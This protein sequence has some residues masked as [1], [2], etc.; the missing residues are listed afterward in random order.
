MDAPATSSGIAPKRSARG[1]SWLRSALVYGLALAA[2]VGSAI[3]FLKTMPAFGQGQG[4]WRASMLAGSQDADLYTR[5]QVAIGGLLALNRSETMYY[6]A[7]TDSQGDVLRSRCTYRIHGTPP[8]A[9]WWSIT[10]YAEDLLSA[11]QTLDRWPEKVRIMQDNW[12]GKSQG[13]R[14]FFK[15]N[16][17]DEEIEVFTTRP[18][19]IFGV[20]FMVLA[21]EHHLVDQLTTD[22]HQVAV[23]QYREWAGSRTNVE[24]ME[25]KKKTGVFTGSYVINPASGDK[26]PVWVADYVLM[27]YGTGAIMAVPAHDERDNEFARAYNLPI[28]VVVEPVTGVKQFDPELRKSIVALVRNPRTDE[29]LTINWGEGSGGRLFVGGGRD[30]GEDIVACATR[31]VIEETG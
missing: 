12:I 20:T 21:P 31:E 24:R 10:A 26:I 4:P 27:D 8:K 14:I 30:E 28:R 16:E 3:G 13:A 15:T 1:G 18:D 11:I 5:A 2:G 22:E 23:K 29:V 17:T 7:R 9:R 25:S 19:T 6:L